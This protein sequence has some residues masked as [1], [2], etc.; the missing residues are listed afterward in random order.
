MRMLSSIPLLLRTLFRRKTVEQ[1]LDEELRSHATDAGELKW[2]N[3]N[4][5]FR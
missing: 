1:E 5:F 3:V 4:Y 2:N